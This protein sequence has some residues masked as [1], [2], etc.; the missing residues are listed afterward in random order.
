MSQFQLYAITPT[1]PQALPVPE[2]TTDFT[3]LYQGLAL[4]VY[5]I[6]RT[7]DHNRFFQLGHH[8]ARTVNSLEMLGWSY[9]LNE[10]RLR[11]AIHDLCTAFPA[12][13][14]R[15]RIDVLAEPATAL[16]VESRELIAL[17][18]FTP[19]PA[20]VYQRGVAIGFA[21]GLQRDN[22]LIKTADFA[23]ERKQASS[24][25]R[26]HDYLLTSDTGEILEA[27]SANF[28]AA[29]NGI[30][31]TA[32]D[33]ILEGVTRRVVLDLVAAEQIP[34]NLQAIQHSEIPTLDEAMISSSSRGILPVVC[35]GDQVIG[36]GRP[37][38]ITQQLIAA[39]NTYVKAHLKTALEG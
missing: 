37:G 1:G 11:C 15:V 10:Q 5:S 21:L 36:S 4:G 26:Y 34:L 12:S 22:P 6:V 28:Y 30:L 32:G 18:P 7:F 3:D 35:I 14:V 8:L 9:S 29:R 2:D 39:Y 20:R 25:E 19:L 33:G 23:V 17:M 31:Y 16:G 27:T 13:E 38:P 24:A